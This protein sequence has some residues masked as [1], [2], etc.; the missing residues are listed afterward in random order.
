MN[1]AVTTPVAG[2]L[3]SSSTRTLGSASTSPVAAERVATKLPNA[4]SYRVYAMS[5]PSWMFSSAVPCIRPPAIVSSA[6]SETCTVPLPLPPPH[7]A[8]ASANTNVATG[9]LITRSFR[10]ELSRRPRKGG[11]RRGGHA[12]DERV[13]RGGARLEH[14]RGDLAVVEIGERDLCD[15]R[16]GVD[17]DGE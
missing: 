16:A 5:Q 8:T 9:V 11:R 2:T 10:C 3:L 17:V 12:D 6:W 7:A 14:H 15:P 1:V 4:M 13:V